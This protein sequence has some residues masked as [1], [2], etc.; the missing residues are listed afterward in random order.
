LVGSLHDG[1]NLV[2]KEFISANVDLKGML[3]L[4]KFTGAA[5]ELKEAVLINPYDIESVADAIKL[6]IEM[7]PDEKKER[8]KKMRENIQENNIYKWAGK[9]ISELIKI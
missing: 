7:P 5:R 9:F 2:A 8:I 1:M 6:A 4:S 3:L